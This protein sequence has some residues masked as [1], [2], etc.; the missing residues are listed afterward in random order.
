M[1]SLTGP[2]KIFTL[3]LLLLFFN[4][5]ASAQTKP[6]LRT[7]DSSAYTLPPGTVIR[8]RMDN[9]INSRSANVNDTFT[10]TVSVPVFVRSIE[11]V[12]AGT[13]IEG[14]VVKVEHAKR[15]GT[16]GF[17]SVTFETLRLPGGAVRKIAGEL[18]DDEEENNSSGT[19][20][21]SVEGDDSTAENVAFIAGGAGAGAV[22]GGLAKGGSGAAIGG[23]I[24]AGAGALASFLR[25][26]EEAVIKT[27][28]QLAVVL[29]QSVTLPARDY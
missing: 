27:N 12:P 19:D 24:G 26:G 28:A 17:I 14:R 15:G 4:Q 2:V 16:A 21:Q 6:Q 10:T 5:W 22:V 25:K 8:V 18:S 9:G 3:L 7:D 13:V 11:V 1:K 29:K 20:G 23:V